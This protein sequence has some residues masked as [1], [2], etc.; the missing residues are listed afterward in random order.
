MDGAQPGR[1]AITAVGGPGNLLGNRLC[2]I[3][4]LLNPPTPG[5]RT[6]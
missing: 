5:V 2:A 4:G 6:G 1:A 3:T